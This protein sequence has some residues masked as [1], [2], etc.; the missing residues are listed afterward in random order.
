MKT[1]NDYMPLSHD[2]NEER[3]QTLKRLYPDLFTNEQMPNIQ[4][5]IKIKLRI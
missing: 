4:E 1:I 3:L 2:W 5:I